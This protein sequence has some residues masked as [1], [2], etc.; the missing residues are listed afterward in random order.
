MS[1]INL[2]VEEEGFVAIVGFSGSGKTALINLISGLQFSD[3]GE[4]LLHG[5]RITGPG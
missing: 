2:S 4:E 3:E 1:D 5:K